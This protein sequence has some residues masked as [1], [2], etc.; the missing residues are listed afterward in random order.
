MAPI[1]EREFPLR[2]LASE[3]MDEVGVAFR[4]GH[5]SPTE[6]YLV[7]KIGFAKDHYEGDET[8]F[9]WYAKGTPL[10]MDY[11]TYTGDAA[12]WGAH[13]VVEMPDADPLRRG[14]LANHLFS[15]AVDY[16]RCE[17][18]V[19]LKLLWGRVRTFAEVD[20]KDGIVDR[21]KTP[22]FYIGDDNPVGPKTWRV[23]QLLFVKP[24]YLVVF[25]RVFGA[26][27]HRFNLHVTGEDIR[28]DGQN[29][30][31]TGRF[32]LD[33][34][35]HVQHPVEFELETGVLVPAPDILGAN[36]P[37]RQ[38]YFRLYNLRD[39]IYRTA[40]FAREHERAVTIESCGCAG[41]KICTPEYTDY[42]FVSDTPVCEQLDDVQFTGKAG[43]I[44][45]DARG[46]LRAVM[47]EGEHLQAFGLTF[48]GRGPWTYNADGS[49]RL[50]VIGTPRPVSIT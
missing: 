46:E 5:P 37:H 15:H 1:P 10:L 48:T 30:H 18:P 19:T 41:M 29:I 34:L 3:V 33:L 40:L 45:R 14:Y 38:S 49:G 42:V 13:N 43:W 25:D 39:G 27:P 6:S 17:V 36:N 32:D 44:R 21:T 7:Q 22:Y 28:R 16:T 35:C 4:H 20:N 31:A 26:V 47:A 9:N 24:D 2:P 12:T 8:A 11:G 50:R 23:R